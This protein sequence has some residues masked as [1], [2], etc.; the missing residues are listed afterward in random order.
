MGSSSRF[1]D[2][3]RWPCVSPLLIYHKSPSLI[4]WG[5]EHRLYDAT[6]RSCIPTLFRAIT[7]FRDS[8][9]TS[10]FIRAAACPRYATHPRVMHCHNMIRS[11]STRGA[12]TYTGPVTSCSAYKLAHMQFLCFFFNP[13]L[14][15]MSGSCWCCENPGQGAKAQCAKSA[16][17]ARKM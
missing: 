17:F 6:L 12:H 13:D 1:W 9:F 16:F 15:Y 8:L 10:Y 2:L 7:S 5:E 4:C 14:T 11:Y 3:A